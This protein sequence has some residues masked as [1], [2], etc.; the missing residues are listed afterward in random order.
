VH[1]GPQEPRHHRRNFARVAQF[2]Q[3]VKV[4]GHQAIMEGT[5]QLATL[6]VSRSNV[7]R[8]GFRA[9]LS[10]CT[11][12]SSGYPTQSPIQSTA[13]SH[14]VSLTSLIRKL[15]WSR[16]GAL[17][18]WVGECPAAMRVAVGRRAGR[19]GPGIGPSVTVPWL[20]SSSHVDA[21]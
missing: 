18:V 16:F 7:E 11:H 13:S 5:N 10:A 21:R 8:H 9:L 4:V 20:E 19:A 3:Q 15:L 6:C 17:L 1:I 14:F 12:E 2:D